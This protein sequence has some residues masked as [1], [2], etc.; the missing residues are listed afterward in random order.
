MRFLVITAILFFQF[1]Y[2]QT[3][4]GYKSRDTNTNVDMARITNEFSNSIKSYVAKR[5]A[6]A[7]KLGWSS[8]AE[9]DAA[10]RANNRKLRHERKM[11]RIEYRIN[12]KKRKAELR[13]IKKKKTIK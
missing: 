3:Y 6:E 2:S 10:R 5:E 12:K 1:N 9:M 11:R 13:R 4:Y 8:A 7:R